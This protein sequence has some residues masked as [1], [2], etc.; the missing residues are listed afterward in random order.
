MNS[1]D[2]TPTAKPTLHHRMLNELNTIDSDLDGLD[3]L[4]QLCSLAVS[5]FDD[6]DAGDAAVVLA[7]AAK[8]AKT[9][10]YTVTNAINLMPE[11]LRLESRL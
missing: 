10:Q 6:D 2:N 4:L 9:A 7:A 5:T 8:R 3:S 1:G 11:L